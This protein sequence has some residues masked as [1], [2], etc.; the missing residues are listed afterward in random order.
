MI[1]SSR[2]RLLLSTSLLLAMSTWANLG[3]TQESSEE[4]HGISN[5]EERELAA[6]KRAQEVGEIIAL[7][8]KMPGWPALPAIGNFHRNGLAWEKA[9]T[10]EKTVR[11]IAQYDLDSVREAIKQYRDLIR[12]EHRPGGDDNLFIL[13]RYLFD[14]PQAVR[15]DSKHFRHF[16]IG[17]RGMPRTGDPKTPKPSDE[18]SVRWPWKEGKDG[19][20]HFELK[21][22]LLI[23]MGPPYRP[24][25]RFDYFRK[26]FGP[27]EIKGEI[28]GLKRVPEFRDTI[29]NS[30]GTTT[31]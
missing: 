6:D 26:H 8:E 12:A 4:R 7:L 25:E 20:W 13:N 15:R 27:R 5:S 31:N 3:F 17:W 28:K 29:R 9:V 23:Y 16:L 21:R 19:R 30:E 22:M 10:L 1:Q 18:F 2:I 11:K 24:L 14:L